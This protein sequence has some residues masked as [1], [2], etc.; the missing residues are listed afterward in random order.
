MRQ[1]KDYIFIC[2]HRHPD[3][4]SIVSALS[5]AHLKRS[6]GIPAI[7]CRL[8]EIND[9][10]AYLLDRFKMEMPVLLK[11][12]RA[13]LDESE[14]DKPTVLHMD[15]SIKD[16]MDKVTQKERTIAIVDDK[17]AMIGIV[18]TSNLAKVSMGDTSATIELLKRTSVTNITKAVDGICLFEPKEFNFNGKTSIIAYGKDG[19]GKYDL[20]NRLV[21]LGND[22]AAQMEAIR[23]GAGAIVI[24]WSDGVSE[25]V[26]ELAKDYNCAIILSSHGSMNTSRYILFSPSVREIMTTDLVTFNKNEFVKEVGRKMLNTRYRSYPV[27]DD[28]G[29]VYGFISRYHILNSNSKR[30]ILVDHNE[31]S[32]SVEGIEEAEVVEIIDHHKIGDITT[33]KPIMFR[34]EVIGSTSSIITKMFLEQDISIPKD[35][36]GLML[37][38]LISDTLNLKSPTTTPQDHELA[39]KLEEISGVNRDELAR[40]MFSEVSSFKHKSFSEIIDM[41]IKRFTIAGK[42]IKVSQAVVYNFDMISGT[43]SDFEEAMETYV[44]KSHLDLLVVIVTSVSEHGSLLLAAGP[45]KDSVLEFYEP[46]DG[47]DIY[48]KDVVSRKNQILPDL[49]KAISNYVG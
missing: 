22:E 1:E 44:E 37:G 39:N 5:Y 8:G 7:A 14:M 23:K 36:A 20:Q 10:T 12:S 26:L 3:T 47:E 13:S 38:A 34:N 29:R 18:T 35:L 28:Y 21:I 24:V 27:L 17:D 43:V 42:E 30:I 16:A 48:L 41:D 2:G 40:D 19:L 25:D 15:A 4:D 45:L 31:L 6:Q 46:K 11:D 9:E 32:Q 33:L 49:F